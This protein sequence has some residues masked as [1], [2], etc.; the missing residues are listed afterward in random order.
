MRPALVAQPLS[1]FETF[2]QEYRL[3][4]KATS[5]APRHQQI[6]FDAFD[7]AM[8]QYDVS[9][10]YEVVGPWGVDSES[11]A[12]AALRNVQD[13]N[14]NYPS[15][16]PQRQAR[17]YARPLYTSSDGSDI[18]IEAERIELI[19]ADEVRQQFKAIVDEAGPALIAATLNVGS[20]EAVKEWRAKEEP[21]L[22]LDG[23]QLERLRYFIATWRV[24]RSTQMDSATRLWFMKAHDYLDE[25]TPVTA[26]RSGHLAQ[27][28]RYA[29]T[30][31]EAL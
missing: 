19:D 26:L 25:G 30:Q 16:D 12:E 14:K 3:L 27:T 17:A 10:S 21:G 2:R 6:A 5:V 13:Y 11:T 22:V 1:P 24:V 15:L 28:F 9:L 23:D 29:V 31:S 7:A 20:V 18:S 4:L 8:P